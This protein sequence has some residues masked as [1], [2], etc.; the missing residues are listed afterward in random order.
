MRYYYEDYCFDQHTLT[1]YLNNKPQALKTNEAKLLA[2]FIANE[3]EIL[4]KEHILSEIWGAQCVSEQV[5]F[6]NISQLRRLFGMQAIKTFPK[7]GYQWQL[8]FEARPAVQSELTTPAVTS[9]KSSV[10]HPLL[11]VS[12]FVV[13]VMAVIFWFLPTENVSNNQQAEALYLIP[14]SLTDDVKQYQLNNFNHLI[15]QSSY[16]THDN[17]SLPKTNTLSLFNYPEITRQSLNL[18]HNSII[19]SGYLSSY[20]DQLLVEYKLLGAKRAWSG[21]VIAQDVESLASS[22]IAIVESL[23]DTAY[24]SEPNSALLSAKL[25]LLLAQQPNNQSIIY[26][27]LQQQISVQDYDVAKA[28]TEKLLSLNEDQPHSPYLAIGLAIKGAIY[29]RQQDF[30][31]ALQYYNLS[32]AQLTDNR[33]LALRHKVEIS[34]AWLAYAQ[35]DIKKVQQHIANAALYAQL[36]KDV[37][38]QVTAHTTGSILSHKLGDMIN[39]YKYLNTGKSLLITHSV[40]EAHFAV[41]HYHLALFATAKQEA[42]SYYLKLLSLPKIAKYQWLYESSTEDLLS[43]YIDQEKWQ[44]ALSLFQSQPENSFNLSQRAKL[45]LAMD[46]NVAARRI[47]KRAFDQARLNY[48][49]NNALHA[50]LLL[51]QL[52]AQSSDPHIRDYQAY[53][54]Q[55]ASKFWLDKHQAEL[56]KLGYF[57]GVTP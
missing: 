56:I 45:L 12:L 49:H 42:E 4:S 46:D 33:F 28:L 16:D 34:L 54:S 52:Q 51:Y 57:D 47:G 50:A 25:R 48:Q 53:I 13:V 9:T 3:A 7:K 5:V 8:A 35:H 15:T 21:Y 18:Q 55:N 30:E 23:Q 20:E 29:H 44:E 37:L 38:A 14:F 36:N 17:D 10:N 19:V 41:I 27:L 43:W 39:R 6:Q 22:L 1:L 32:L 2:L 40:A 24:L 31:Q 26:H 11:A